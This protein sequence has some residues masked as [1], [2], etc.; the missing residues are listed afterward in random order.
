MAEPVRLLRCECMAVKP[1]FLYLFNF[2]P[3]YFFYLTIDAFDQKCKDTDK[4]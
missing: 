1:T 4:E 2:T 3:F